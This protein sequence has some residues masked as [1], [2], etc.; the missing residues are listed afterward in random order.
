MSFNPVPTQTQMLPGGS[1]LRLLERPQM[2]RVGRAIVLMI[3]RGVVG[4]V[5]GVRV[6]P[7][8]AGTNVSD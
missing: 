3:G 7:C 5:S 6:R 4:D 2:P 1:V 8:G